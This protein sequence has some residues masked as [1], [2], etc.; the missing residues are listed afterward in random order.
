MNKN[1]LRVGID[2][3]KEHLDCALTVDGVIILS[4][5]R[6]KN[7]LLGFN[8]TETWIGKHCKKNMCDEIH[9][10]FESTGVY[11]DDL[12]DYLF[13][14]GKYK[15]SIVNPMQ[16]KGFARSMMLRTKTDKVDAGMLAIY[17]AK[18]NPRASL[19]VPHEIMVFKKLQS[20]AW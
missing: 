3:S 8:A 4:T 13:E 15:I 7:N 2:V 20:R 6:V 9:I 10:C 12:A 19:K 16:T 14:K 18:G 17:C 5:K 11:D 1:V